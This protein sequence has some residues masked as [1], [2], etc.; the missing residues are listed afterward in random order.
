MA[1]NLVSYIGNLGK[2]VGYSTID[3]FKKMS[4][5]T[6][7]LIETNVEL[8]KSVT[9]A[10][11]DYRNTYKRGNQFIKKSKIYEAG[12]VYFKS[13]MQDISTG[14]FYNKE[15]Q[16]QMDERALGMGPGSSGDGFD[17]G[18]PD[19]DFN[20]SEFD[21]GD[22][23][24]FGS[25]TAGDEAIVSSV[26]RSSKQNADAVST[27]IA[28]TGQYIVE[29]QRLNSNILFTQ[30]LQAFGNMTNS[31][32]SI[33]DNI[34][35]VLQFSN[36][37]LQTHA[38]NSQ[39][40]YETTTALMQEQTGYLKQIAEGLNH[41]KAEEKKHEK[42]SINDILGVQGAPNLSLY[43]KQLQKNFNNVM[44]TYMPNMDMGDGNALLTL[45]A[46]PL[47]FIP[48][49][50]VN[51]LVPKLVE[52]SITNFNKSLS[53]VFGAMMTKANTMAKSDNILQSTIGKLLGIS[54]GAK[55]DINTSNYDK[56]KVNWDGKSKKALEEVI[57]TYLARIE[58]L[59]SG[60]SEKRFDYE[61]GKFID[62]RGIKESF[63][64]I[65]KGYN[66][67]ATEDIREEFAKYKDLISFN[68]LDEKE[69]FDKDVSKIFEY[70][71]KNNEIFD[72]NNKDF[73]DLAWKYG[74]DGKNLRIFRRLFKEAPRHQQ[75]NLNRQIMEQRQ[76]QTDYMNRL[77]K[78]GT[79]YSSMFNGLDLNEFVNI[80]KKTGEVKGK[81]LL[82]GLGTNLR[83][84]LDEK[85]HNVFYYLR[86]INMELSFMRKNGLSGGRG[87]SNNTTIVGHDGRTINLSPNFNDEEI[88]DDS[89]K[90]PIRQWNEDRA[91]AEASYERQQNRA[92]SKDEFIV[93]FSE[94]DDDRHADFRLRDAIGMRRNKLR[95]QEEREKS[96]KTDFIEELLESDSLIKK[97]QKMK[98]KGSN[99]L[100]KPM[101]FISNVFRKADQRLYE[102]VYGTGDGKGF[103]DLLVDNTK[104]TFRRLNDWIDDKILEPLKKKLDIKEF[105][106]LGKKFF[107]MFGIDTDDFGKRFKTYFFGN[108]QTGEKGLFS[109]I[110]DGLK[111]SFGSFKKTIK[112]AVSGTFKDVTKPFRDKFKR[113]RRAIQDLADEE[114]NDEELQP[115]D[116]SNYDYSTQRFINNNIINPSNYGSNLSED[117]FNDAFSSQFDRDDYTV[118]YDR[119]RDSSHNQLVRQARKVRDLKMA[120]KEALDRATDPSLSN[121]RRLDNEKKVRKLARKIRVETVRLNRLKSAPRTRSNYS[122]F[123]QFSQQAAQSAVDDRTNTTNYNKGRLNELLNFT[124]A[125]TSSLSNSDMDILLSNIRGNNIADD[126]SLDDIISSANG[127]YGNKFRNVRF[128]NISKVLEAYKRDADIDNREG[129]SLSDILRNQY[130]PIVSDGKDLKDLS[131]Q[132][133]GLIRLANEEQSGFSSKMT[134]KATEYLKD[135]RD[136]LFDLKDKFRSNRP[137]RPPSIFDTGGMGPAPVFNPDI[138]SSENDVMWGKSKDLAVEIMKF[139]SGN[140]G[141]HRT[142]TPVLKEPELATLKEGEMVL[143]PEQ[144]KIVSKLIDSI[145]GKVEMGKDKLSDIAADSYTKFSRIKEAT[146]FK[147]NELDKLSNDSKKLLED[148]G[149]DFKRLEGLVVKKYNKLMDALEKQFV[150]DKDLDENGEPKDPIQK[151][152]YQN[153]KPFTFQMLDEFRNG[154][155]SIKK[156]LF[157]DNERQDKKALSKAIT[158]ISDNISE[159]A[160]KALPAALIGSGV[161]LLT[162]MIG[163]PI[164]GAAVGAGSSIVMNSQKTQDWLFGEKIADER[165][166]GVISKEVID[167]FGKYFPDA[168]KYGIT[169]ALAGMIAPFGPVGGLFLGAG[170]SFVKNNTAVQD[171]LFGDKGLFNESQ[172]EKISKALPRM[173]LGALIGTTLGPFGLVGNAFLGAG[174]GFLTTSNKFTDTIIGK[175]NPVTKKYEDGILPALRES[176][177]DPLKNFGNDMKE[178]VFHF[179][180]KDIFAPLKSAFDPLKKDAKLM[181][182]GIFRTLGNAFDFFFQQAWG[183]PFRKVAHD[184]TSKVTG[185]MKGFL[186]KGVGL[187]KHVVAAP[188]KAIGAYGNMRRKSHVKNG[189]A[190][191]MTAAERLQ[192]AQEK[193]I[194]SKLGKFDELLAGGDAQTITDLQNAF[195]SFMDLKKSDKEKNQEIGQETIDKLSPYF[196]SSDLGKMLKMFKN[197]AGTDAIKN[198]K[199]ISMNNSRANI[200]RVYKELHP[201]YLKELGKIYNKAE[202]KNLSEKDINSLKLTLKGDIKRK[203]LKEFSSDIQKEIL[204]KLEASVDERGNSTSEKTGE[205][206]K[207]IAGFNKN[208]D[209]NSSNIDNI[210]DEQ[211]HKLDT[212]RDNKNKRTEVTS[213][214]SKKMKEFGINIDMNDPRQLEKAYNMINTEMGRIRTEQKMNS[215]ADNSG[216]ET[217]ADPWNESLQFSRL[218]EEENKNRHKDIVSLFMQTINGIRQMNGEEA[219]DVAADLSHKNTDELH[220]NIDKAVNGVHG[221][222]G[223]SNKY[224]ANLRQLPHTKDG[225]TSGNMSDVKLNEADENGIVRTVQD[226]RIIQFKRETDGSYSADLSDSATKEWEE[227]NQKQKKSSLKDKLSGFFGKKDD[228]EKPDGK[229]EKKSGG[230]L[231]SILGF[232]GGGA[233]SLL[234]GIGL[235]ILGI[236]GVGL[237]GKLFSN[238]GFGKFVTDKVIPTVA[239]GLVGLLSKA[240]PVL[241]N[242]FTEG[243]KAVLPAVFSGLTS[244]VSGEVKSLFPQLFPNADSKYKE[245]IDKSLAGNGIVRTIAKGNTSTFTKIADKFSLGKGKTILGTIGN[246]L[247][248]PIKSSLKGGIFGVA[249]ISEKASGLLSKFTNPINNSKLFTDARTAIEDKVTKFAT[250]ALN[251]VYSAADNGVIKTFI[252]KLRN[253]LME[254][255]TNPVVSKLLGD[256]VSGIVENFIPRLVRSVEENAA[257]D[258]VKIAGKLTAIMSTGGLASIAFGVADFVS[259]Y[260]DA[261]NI[262]GITSETDLTIG[263][264][265]GAGFLKALQGAFLITSFIPEDL[266]MGLIIDYLLP[267][268]DSADA[269]LLKQKREAAKQEVDQYNKDNNTNYDT[270]SYNA[271]V[272][273]HKTILQKLGFGVSMKDKFKAAGVDESTP[274]G[275][276]FLD[277]LDRKEKLSWW[278]NIKDN[279]SQLGN[280]ISSGWNWLKSKFT[281]SGGSYD[282]NVKDDSKSQNKS[283]IGGSYDNANI[284]SKQ[285]KQLGIEQLG[286]N[287]KK[288]DI[289]I[290]KYTGVGGEFSNVIPFAKKEQYT[291]LGGEIQ[292]I[293]TGTDALSS[294]VQK[295]AD[296]FNQA[297]QQYGVDP[298]FLEAISMQ[299]SG[300]KADSNNGA[301][302]GLMQ[303]ENGGTTDEFIQFGK[304]L[305]QDW[306]ADDRADPTKAIPFAAKRI[307]DL[308]KHYNGDYLKVTQAYNFSQYSLDALIKAFGDKWMDHRAEVGQYNGTGLSSYGDPQYVEHVLRYY[309]GSSLGSGTATGSSGDGKSSNSDSGGD[310]LSDALGIFTNAVGRF[311]GFS[312]NKKSS[313]SSSSSGGAGITVKNAPDAVKKAL[314]FAVSK[315]GCPYVWGGTGDQLTEATVNQYI[316]SDHDIT[317]GDGANDN[318]KSWI[319]KEG[320]DCS[321][322]TSKAYEAAGIDVGRDTYAQVTHGTEVSQSEM[323]PGDLIFFGSASAPH[324]VGMCVGNGKMVEA[325]KSGYTVRISDL[326]SRSDICSV[327]R[328]VE[329][330]GSIEADITGADTAKS[331]GATGDNVGGPYT[332]NVIDFRDIA[333]K[334]K[335]AIQ[336]PY[337]GTGGL[338]DG[339]FSKTLDG[340]VTSGYGY[341]NTTGTIGKN[342]TGIDIGA[343]QG[344]QIEAP[345]GGVVTKKLPSDQSNGLGNLLVMKDQF[346]GEHMFGHMENP[347]NLKPGDTVRPGDN[348]GRVGTTGNSTGPHLHYETRV[349]GKSVDPNAYLSTAKGGIG[350]EKDGG[351]ILSS[352]SNQKIIDLLTTIANNTL[353]LNT[354]VKLIQLIAGSKDDQTQASNVTAADKDTIRNAGTNMASLLANKLGSNGSNTDQDLYSLLQQIASK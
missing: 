286:F 164:L 323:Q 271:E 14:K 145:T 196:G 54:N 57:P 225:F 26:Q 280:Q 295:Y 38:S 308:I 171:L 245:D 263:Q 62:A 120:Y 34:S 269:D 210:I 44:S 264:K 209:E 59:L 65:Q 25:F 255:V 73:D 153:V 274:E 254:L 78:E 200:A 63:K 278:D 197:G 236:A 53:G 215:E 161:S 68:K 117:Y 170:A 354:I 138:D 247:K 302:L 347:S 169:G 314:E 100:K 217:S 246:I 237:L 103:M 235:P 220:E 154:V 136:F 10:I 330:S 281:G 176:I 113:R 277:E 279:A 297:G 107:G 92:R 250:P 140:T 118:G 312:D 224:K 232:F 202:K 241:V 300:G 180:Q 24:E 35:K 341:R 168:K 242:L 335:K 306:S 199:S 96:K 129:K 329:S 135:I 137:N 228:K 333:R 343:Q 6:N 178:Q 240:T 244:L 11:M 47:Q 56:D 191:Y 160:P 188:F 268:F 208:I 322:L 72:I 262:Y 173:G 147:F 162:G 315:V 207:Y 331:D 318:W 139:L 172:K 18:S 39:K 125:D 81:G 141:H 267:I 211:F 75:M 219:L 319:G 307:S 309:T 45:V 182:N 146:G 28:R 346:G 213:E 212:F 20:E 82:G 21:I 203:Y 175:Y 179:L 88:K 87:I 337:N 266:V 37:V 205:F 289:G 66:N 204:D 248:H 258:A 46:Q 70:L 221:L 206:Q 19:M 104:K 76:A 126:Y 148:N 97:Y 194:R 299:E 128:K 49:M 67:K 287:T 163:G 99:I 272:K 109:N 112:D 351:N 195:G 105:K 152:L 114:E 223:V 345:I 292:G 294:D 234:S 132:Y 301:A 133:S 30:N 167:A 290:E 293:Q 123:N 305:G 348:I 222:K 303:I 265:V 229:E 352:D 321:G 108:T 90:T 328:I 144:V 86:N 304:S 282:R 130:K 101:D 336:T 273:G 71:Y 275:K 259:G 325:P 256:K 320:Y 93:N 310:M 261:V 31:L 13:I 338:A 249:K 23:S 94:I 327:R 298:A 344:H 193:G 79:I 159:Y 218:V 106:D 7:E 283:G 186:G 40:Y 316:G 231:D 190:D 201:Y 181:I 216:S 284:Y 9:S 198:Q 251:K 51:A 184:V 349:N 121:S 252:T 177:V 110:T 149:F 227:D 324:H 3:K 43:A 32:N 350:G 83:E 311:F 77:E 142:G 33:N 166:G 41:Q 158:D 8:Y 52:E 155:N 233:S 91:R 116:T 64:N 313:G 226:G 334:K 58:S 122:L 16:S 124:G 98:E 326:S 134:D 61:K 187:A 2:S 253:F 22:D 127:L 339:F 276:K 95:I 69:N 15:R 288:K 12:D 89:K 189:E 317:K 156:S 332:N 291:G 131:D 5:T 192:F 119:S 230:I 353:T 340:N 42:I 143:S 80:H 285:R 214:F 60:Q 165:Q 115:Q 102:M 260:N 296:T 238:T 84:S 342:H 111:E 29:N 1:T 150:L 4:P 85:G 17:W 185:W 74:V 174:A 157:G 270:R 243:V 239:D 55:N 27:A 257:K 183:V 50:I 151:A 36:N 48:N